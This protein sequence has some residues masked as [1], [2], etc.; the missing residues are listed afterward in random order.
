MRAG[1]ARSIW[2]R[3]GRWLR[4]G[5]RQARHELMSAFFLLQRISVSPAGMWTVLH[6][7]SCDVTKDA[8]GVARASARPSTCSP[9]VFTHGSAIFPSPRA[10]FAVFVAATVNTQTMLATPSVL[11]RPARHVS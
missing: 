3:D 5:A 11:R 1:R 9:Q 4:Q 8:C 7:A 2:T 10:C 6:A